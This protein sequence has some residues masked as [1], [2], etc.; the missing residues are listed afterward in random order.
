[1]SF[2]TEMPP[3][4]STGL[5]LLPELAGFSNIRSLLESPPVL[6][7]GMGGAEVGAP[8]GTEGFA[9]LVADQGREGGVA[10]LVP[11]GMGD[12]GGGAGEPETH[13]GKYTG[14]ESVS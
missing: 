8:A 1:M 5:K 11:V 14:C 2:L 13:G 6:D 3:S 9:G 4:I 7:A 10:A 12:R